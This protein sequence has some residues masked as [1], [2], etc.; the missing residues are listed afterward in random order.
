ML[1]AGIDAILHCFV[2][3]I[4]QDGAISQCA[5]AKLGSP[6]EP[7]DDLAGGDVS[8]HRRQQLL[9]SHPPIGQPGSLEGTRDLGVGISEAVEGVIELE[10]A[11][12]TKRLMIVP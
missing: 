3:G 8:G 10:A 1:H 4:G 6:L 2:P 5:R 9:F 7:A 12:M 11:R